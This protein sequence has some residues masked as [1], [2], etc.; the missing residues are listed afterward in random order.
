MGSTTTDPSSSAAGPSSSGDGPFS[1]PSASSSVSAPQPARRPPYGGKYCCVVECHNSEYRDHER[2]I[3]FHRFPKNPSRRK[4]WEVAVKRTVQGKRGDLWRA[5]NHD[6]I[7]SEHFVGGKKSD[8]VGNPAYVPSIFPTHETHH[9]QRE[10]ARARR[11]R[12]REEQQQARREKAPSTFTN[13]DGGGADNDND[14]DGKNGANGGGGG[15]AGC[16]NST[17]TTSGQG[18]EEKATTERDQGNPWMHEGGEEEWEYG[19]FSPS[20]IPSDDENVRENEGRGGGKILLEYKV[21]ANLPAISLKKGMKVTA[22]YVDVV[23]ENE[24]SCQV[25]SELIPDELSMRNRAVQTS[26]SEAV[27]FSN[28][29]PRQM[30]AFC[31]V[32]KNFIEF[33]LYRSG[34][35]VSDSKSL[36]REGKVMLLLSKL[37]LNVSFSV[38][39]GFF[40]VSEASA[41]RFFYE[42]LDAIY[43]TVK[44]DIIWFDKKTIQARMPRS[45]RALFPNTRAVIDC[46]EIETEIPS[47]VR[48][49]NLTY[50]AYKS[51][52][53]VKVLVA[54]APSGEIMFVSKA[55]G[56]RATD[57][58]ITVDSG[59]L[60]LVEEGDVIMSDKGFPNIETDVNKCGGILVM[61]PFKQGAR[62]FSPNQA[63]D[64]YECASVRVHVERCIE[65]LKRFEAL[66]F[67]PENMRKNLDKIL[68][69][70]SFIHNC[71]NDL[72][73]DEE[74]E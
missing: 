64:S 17:T 39:G 3:K 30:K 63:K 44:S 47:T 34:E 18:E 10:D 65:R 35:R 24:K 51:R 22:C 74:G 53:T 6:V 60:N 52:Y 43:E 19:D 73:Q 38:L 32:E 42:M 5:S 72:I 61:P 16:S 40:N 71:Q 7:C 58:Q 66:T 28:F 11:Q 46:T 31:G 15:G 56:G 27:L 36:N 54:I 33:L 12:Q 4:S 68:V 8:V 49:R 50:S 57:C 29:S 20:P 2:G 14:G 25:S 48:A 45:F 41:I 1:S 37:K 67:V 13:S 9:H 55:Y 69:I 62:Q 21:Q 70:V 59:F 26:K 23:S